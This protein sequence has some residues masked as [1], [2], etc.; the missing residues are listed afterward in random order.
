M[1]T[2]VTNI[3]EQA[4]LEKMRA[5]EAFTALDISNALKADR[6]PVRHGEVAEAVRDIYGSGAMGYYDY[7]RRLIDVVADGG[8][9]KTQAF[10]YL[11]TETRER[12]Y[13]ARSQESLPPVPDDQARDLSDCAAAS[14][15]P[16]LPRPQGRQR[17]PKVPRTGQGRRDGAL[18]VPRALVER[19][20]WTEGMSLALRCESGQMQIAPRPPILGE[21]EVRVWGGRRV[22]VCKNKLQRGGLTADNVTVEV[23]TDGS[24]RLKTKEG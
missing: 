20:G 11:H 23:T 9:K 15:L 21:S 8:A 4:V 3:V 24:L 16:L 7:D 17:R 6:Y 12:E 13:T 5:R 18:P 22:R 1:N 19:L 2:Q 14:P 10:L